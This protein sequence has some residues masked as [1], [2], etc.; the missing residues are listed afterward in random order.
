[1]QKLFTLVLITLSLNTFALSNYYPEEF[2]SKF[3]KS[4]LTDE[5]LKDALFDVLSMSHTRRKGKPDLLG[6]TGKEGVCYSQKVLGYRGARKILFGKL[7]LEEDKNGY[8][9]KEVYCRKVYT[10]AQTNIGPN[11]IPNSNKVNCEHTWP[12]SKFSRRFGKEMQKSDLHHLYP[13]D[14]RANSIRGNYEFGNVDDHGSITNC[15]ASNSESPGRFE[16]P[17]E[18]KGN[19]ARAVFYFSVRYKM[20]IGAQQERTLR[21][22]NRLDP[23]DAEERERNDGIYAVQGNRNPFIDFP[24]MA[25]NIR[26]F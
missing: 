14:S 6:C 9:L 25:D 2:T 11:K 15:E 18:H 21:E 16:P 10:P 24:H 1:M 23:I 5:K 8:Y 3:Q 17:N 22:W 26:D 20:E 4:A 19:V 7:H 12:Q 13:T